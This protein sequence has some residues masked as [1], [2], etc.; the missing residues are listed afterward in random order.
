MNNVVDHSK[1]W[2]D[3]KGPPRLR[4]ASMVE[5]P[6]SLGRGG[7]NKKKGRYRRR[8]VPGDSGSFEQRV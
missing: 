1:H 7:R 2:N 5:P 3:V 4:P 6:G 8:Y